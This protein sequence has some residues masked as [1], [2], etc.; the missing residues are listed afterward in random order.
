MIPLPERIRPRSLAEVIG[1]R[2]LLGAGAPLRQIVDQGKLP[3]MIL[4]GAAGVGK[5]TLALLLAEAVDRPLISLSAINTG[6][7]ELR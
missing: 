2:H 7:K 4:W 5:T 6:V 3:S 1:Q